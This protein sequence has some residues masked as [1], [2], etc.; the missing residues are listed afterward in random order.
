MKLPPHIDRLFQ[1]YLNLKAKYNMRMATYDDMYAKKQ[2][3][4]IAY[5]DYLG[6]F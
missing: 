2:L 5:N 4:L 1:D 3:Y 6:R